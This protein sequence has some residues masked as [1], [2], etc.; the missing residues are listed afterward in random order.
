MRPIEISN[1][2]GNP[3]KK[4]SLKKFILVLNYL[5]MPQ[6]N[7]DYTAILFKIS[8]EVMYRQVIL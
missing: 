3:L 4:I 5:A 6:I 7:L 1:R 2:G 8:I